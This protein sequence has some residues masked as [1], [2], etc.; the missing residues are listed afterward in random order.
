MQQNGKPIALAS[1]YFF[2]TEEWI[3][4]CLCYLVLLRPVLLQPR[5]TG[6]N[7]RDVS[8]FLKALPGTWQ[9]GRAPTS[10]EEHSRRVGVKL[11][12][13]ELPLSAQKSFW[14]L[15]R[16]GKQLWGWKD[17][18]KVLL[19]LAAQRRKGIP[20]WGSPRYGKFAMWPASLLGNRLALGRNGQSIRTKAELS[21]SC[22]VTLAW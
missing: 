12:L 9:S 6:S 7:T 16:A 13:E 21:H 2:S 18:S 1:A 14:L 5:K 15:F 19:A 22:S 8:F 10:L 11:P 17:G 20:R 3:S 4:A